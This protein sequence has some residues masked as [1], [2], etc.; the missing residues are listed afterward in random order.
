M[1]KILSSLIIVFAL[2]THVQAQLVNDNCTNAQAIVIPSSGSVCLTSTNAGATSDNTTNLCDTGPAGN[3]VWFT[4]IVAGGVNTITAR[5]TGANPASDLVVTVISTGCNSGTY[6]V[7]ANAT[8]SNSAVATIGLQVGTQVWVSVETNGTDGAFELCIQSV[9]PA[10]SPGNTCPLATPICSYNDFTVANMS[11]FSPSGIRPPCFAAAV[12]RDAWFKF[13][14]CQTGTLEWTATPLQ[15][16]EFDWAVFDVTDGCLGTEV[17]CNYNYSQGGPAA[18]C[19]SVAAPFGMRPGGTGEFSAPIT[20]QAGRTY[21]I[22]IDNFCNNN[23]GFSFAW[24]NG[25]FKLCPTAEFSISPN[26]SCSVPLT[27]NITN[28]TVGAVSQ[29]WNFGNGQTSTSA[30]P[31]STTYN[32]TGDYLIS[33][34]ATSADG[35]VSV[36][37]QR[38]NLNSGPVISINPENPIVCEGQSANLSA[39]IALGT[40]FNDRLYSSNVNT[41]IPNNEA[42]GLTNTLNSTGMVNTSIGANMLQSICFTINHTNH[43]DIGRG[44]T[45]DAVTITVNG[46]T[47]NYTPLPL[48]NVNG[49]GTYCFPQ[50]VINAINAAGGPSNTSWT[51]KVADNRGGGG[52]TGSLVSWEVILR[53]P[54]SITN[55]LW[56]PTTNM[57]NSTSLT[58]T[59]SP[60]VTTTYNLSAT[61]AFGCSTSRNVTVNVLPLP[62][63][64][65]SGTQ[66]IC[67]GQSATLTINFTGTGPWNVSY[68]DGVSTTNLTGISSNPFTFTTS[69]AGTYTLTSVSNATCTG[70]VSGTAVVSVNPLISVSNIQ[71]I[72]NGGVYNVSFQINGGNPAT[73]QVT[74]GPGTI[75]GNIFTSADITSGTG[76]NF[77]V[78]D[79]ANCNPQTVSGSQNCACNVSASISGGGSFCTGQNANDIVFNLSGGAVS[80]Y[81][82]VYTINGVPQAP[83]TVTDGFPNSVFTLNN[84]GIGTYAIQSIEDGDCTGSASGSVTV[85]ALPLPTATVSGGGVVC[86]GL[87]TPD[88][89]F[90]LT[91]TGPF[92]LTYSNGSTSVNVTGISSSPFVISNPA[93]GTY[94]VTTIQDQNCI[95]TSSGSVNVVVNPRPVISGDFEICRNATSQLTATNS[96]AL[97][98]PWISSNPTSVTVNS[99]GL[100][101][102]IAS[103]TSIITYTDINGCSSSETVVVNSNPT[104]SISP[105]PALVCAGDDL[106]MNGSPSG[107]SGIYTTHLWSNTG[108]S[109]LSTTNIVNPTFNNGVA[110]PYTL[111]YTV[112]DDNNCSASANIT[113]NV[114][115]TPSIDPVGPIVACGS[116][117]L[118][119]IT[120]TDLT[121][122][123]AYYNNTQANGGTV[124]TGTI[125]SSTVLYM[126]DGAS[127]CSDEVMVSITINPLPT[128]AS[129]IGSGQYCEGD[130]VSDV[131]VTVTGSADWTLNY[132]LD[133]VA[134]TST[135]SVSP[136][137]L[138]NAAGVYTLTSI[139]DANCTNT[140]TGS[141]TI[142]VFPRPDAPSVSDAVTYCSTVVFDAMTATGGS[143]TMTWY[144]DEDLTSVYGTGNSIAPA[145]VL[146]A[147]TYY[148]TETAN[149]CEGPSSSIVITVEGCD[150]IVSTAITPNGDGNNDRWV[151]PNLDDAYPDAIVR[152]YNRWGSLLFEHNSATMGKYNDNAWDGSF[153][154]TALPV[155]SYFFIIEFNDANK[156][157]L[158]GA[159]SI[160]LQ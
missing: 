128:V 63:A 123:Q 125:T 51:L 26:T 49:V 131:L 11:A 151:I 50:S 36:A 143:G 88:V 75:T 111:T 20:V 103:G 133:G 98:N 139:S 97:S 21:A 55:Y 27:V 73:Y 52:G 29:S 105:S 61:D 48:P 2:I 109:S 19:T 58:P 37:S 149:G 33:L 69:S 34:T 17:A 70:T 67:S 47:Y 127:G 96:P 152:I 18:P 39:A 124:V 158:N 108:S 126:Y 132:T 106:E 28:T 157:K 140:A 147:T 137:N 40:P 41:A 1:K 74:G 118:P 80:P 102:A 119:T 30:N 114:V 14:V 144:T 6:D 94:T 53:D 104:V 160:I 9:P 13:T 10:P 110:G 142:V 145:N 81:T 121:G 43:S 60:T 86:Q 78:T 112:T 90:N 155:G 71:V 31:G 153:N 23:T 62:T 116:F 22:V 8:G 56:S 95:G 135:G 141:A 107:G 42:N 85:T 148:V 91:G 7:C 89:V 66:S 45:P 3:E 24:G 65:L 120:G 83:V 72:C 4:Y 130:L 146:G 44:P 46:V 101:S 82:L 136:L 64:T 12:R 138:G 129:I 156:E 16:T 134:Q 100:I 15:P 79:A 87:A 84:P 159:V 113:V 57:S 38:V 115:A 92:N 93:A 76:Y 154:G 122:N 68:S 117:V 32:A 59:V 77:T 25:T 54:N 150:I 99:T 35:C 5:P